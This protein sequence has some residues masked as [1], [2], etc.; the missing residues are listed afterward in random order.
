M[1]P[2]DATI[3]D[4]DLHDLE[5]RV[6][7]LRISPADHIRITAVLAV[8]V[9]RG[10]HPTTRA[11]LGRVLAPLLAR[12]E[13]QQD[14]IREFYEE[15]VRELE[16]TPIETEEEIAS[17]ET[18]ELKE[19]AIDRTTVTVRVVALAIGVLLALLTF[20]AL[21]SG[22]QI[23]PDPV[24]HLRPKTGSDLTDV[25][26]WV[27]IAAERINWLLSDIGGFRSVLV[28]IP[29]IFAGAMFLRLRDRRNAFLDP[30]THELATPGKEIPLPVQARQVL[31]NRPTLHSDLGRLRMHREIRSNQLDIEDT[32]KAAARNAGYVERITFQKRERAVEHL[33]LIDRE[34]PSDHLGLLGDA[35]VERLI[36]ADVPVSSFDLLRNPALAVR[37]GSLLSKEVRPTPVSQHAIA[38]N[39][40]AVVVISDCARLL[41]R[42]GHHLAG[43]LA[44]FEDPSMIAVLTPLPKGS[45]G[46]AERRLQKLG[47]TVFPLTQDGMSDYVAERV[48]LNADVPEQ[49]THEQHRQK[50]A[51]WPILE[52][53]RLVDN[54][55]TD[56]TI[57]DEAIF[58][59]RASL[60]ERG[61][62]L[63]SI[64]SIFPVLLPEL[65]TRFSVVLGGISEEDLALI[66]S[67]K[68][69]RQGRLPYW[70]R[71]SLVRS[72]PNEDLRQ[73]HHIISR[74]QDDIDLSTVTE[75]SLTIAAEEEGLLSFLRKFGHGTRQEM[76]TDAI[77]VRFARGEIDFSD[78]VVEAKGNLLQ[79]IN[80]AL[81]LQELL[82]L[83]FGTLAA[84]AAWVAAP[85]IVDAIGGQS[86]GGVDLLSLPNVLGPIGKLSIMCICLYLYGFSHFWFYWYQRRPIF[87][88]FLLNIG[89]PSLRLIY[90]MRDDR[91]RFSMRL[92]HWVP[93]VIL[94]PWLFLDL[95]QLINTD[96]IVSFLTGRSL[97]D[98]IDMLPIFLLMV[99]LI[100]QRRPTLDLVSMSAKLS[101][102][103]IFLGS[104]ALV[105]TTIAGAAAQ[106][107]FD[108]EA[109]D[110][111]FTAV[112]IIAFLLSVACFANDKPTLLEFVRSMGRSCFALLPLAL[113]G[114]ATSDLFVLL[115][116]A[117]F[118]LPLFS[119]IGGATACFLFLLLPLLFRGGLIN[120]WEWLTGVI[121]V[122]GIYFL[123]PEALY[124]L[125]VL[126]GLSI[127]S[128][129][130]TLAILV[131]GGLMLRR[132]MPRDAFLR[133]GAAAVVM[134][135]GLPIML[136]TLQVP[137]AFA[138]SETLIP[139]QEDITTSP[140]EIE[141]DGKVGGGI[142]PEP[143]EVLGTPNVG[144]EA[145]PIVEDTAEPLVSINDGL[146]IV[147]VYLALTLLTGQLIWQ[148]HLA[149]VRGSLPAWDQGPIEAI[150]LLPLVLL[151]GFSVRFSDTFSFTLLF[152]PIFLTVGASVRW[153]Y[154]AAVG[155][156]AGML[157]LIGQT[158]IAPNT[159]YGGLGLSSI[160][161]TI[162]LTRCVAERGFFAH[163]LLVDTIRP[164][165]LLIVAL[166]IQF[167]VG[168]ELP[169]IA[170]RLVISPREL[171]YVTIVLV[172]LSRVP[173]RLPALFLIAISAVDLVM[174]FVGIQN[175]D[176]WLI[177][178]SGF[179]V[180]LV[181]SEWP[182]VMIDGLLTLGIVRGLR[183]TLIYGPGPNVTKQDGPILGWLI[184]IFQNPYA[185]G[186]VALL[187]AFNLNVMSI[188]TEQSYL[189]IGASTTAAFVLFILLGVGACGTPKLSR[190]GVSE[191]PMRSKTVAMTATTFLLA[192]FGNLL[193]S[194]LFFPTGVSL[195]SVWPFEFT[196]F[197]T[198]GPAS[199]IYTLLLVVLMFLIG[200][201]SR[202]FRNMIV[203]TPSLWVKREIDPRD[204]E[205]LDNL[206][207]IAEDSKVKDGP[208]K[209]LDWQEGFTKSLKRKLIDF[210]FGML[211]IKQELSRILNFKV[212]PG[213]QDLPV[214][215]AGRSVEALDP[216]RSRFVMAGLTLALAVVLTAALYVV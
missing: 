19:L 213:W 111:L 137:L 148:R 97:R 156:I 186:L 88:P 187:F 16:Q 27:A 96:D 197:Y 5:A 154:W 194:I 157:P 188:I 176:T 40:D 166:M 159:L 136:S 155:G 138:Q 103:R 167:A 100:R 189:A 14:S 122:A 175:P 214:P 172:G 56:E 41:D 11:A 153:G 149:V 174:F 42:R 146:A 39:S 15:A 4:L 78:V 7:G 135:L 202:G 116:G 83:A 73:T 47:V 63:L 33:V 207:D 182:F 143:A 145:E 9:D 126:R 91:V 98:E 66:S 49:A 59:L 204:E 90:D 215:I 75:R 48:R 134:A 34:A 69:V 118:L 178:P 147:S 55:E 169:E 1:N 105:T 12:N 70:L 120:V 25:P 10:A 192:V 99:V 184:Q 130:P 201:Y 20:F 52:A 26:T 13:T 30:E 152:L 216:T 72:L 74:F 164:V 92:K 211:V 54:A 190:F 44:P 37:R 85:W 210:D 163:V 38:F 109:G 115:Q 142:V 82:V 128:F 8:L 212:P 183:N 117:F 200:F 43:W 81:R 129:M 60:G 36:E 107:G 31:F 131:I 171:L 89:L 113:L 93:P 65:T 173:L 28:A 22:I 110:E 124:T 180:K 114:A 205:W 208:I 123:S 45:W 112:A 196:A 108:V 119:S 58:A 140:D 162:A 50:G 21:T 206:E 64:L 32:V 209:L 84:A 168:Y 51:I 139:L 17:D 106:I 151:L 29:V 79:A 87:L 193:A 67:L 125:D 179:F 141:P 95:L 80:P 185:L 150:L 195:G 198:R 86:I 104:V 160:V 158:G 199:G 76:I 203:A 133:N 62:R 77:F 191:N 132:Q 23:S 71:E 2:S 3:L 61:F 24:K 57:R 102:T 68:I 121:T 127:D 94:V 53:S 177:N 18:Q 144:E 35:F 161:I 165:H 46:S 170:M 181:I 101:L 6:P